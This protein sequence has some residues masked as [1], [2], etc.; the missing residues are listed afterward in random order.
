[1][2]TNK[3]GVSTRLSAIAE[4]AKEDILSA[5]DE[6]IL[7]EA[8]DDGVNPIE[9]VSE[10]RSSALAKIRTAKRERLLRARDSYDRGGDLKG[11]EATALNRRDQKVGAGRDPGRCREWPRAGVPKGQ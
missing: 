1:M 11:H 4:L 5:S 2:T 10:L 6:A 9:K 8:A 3:P 7:A